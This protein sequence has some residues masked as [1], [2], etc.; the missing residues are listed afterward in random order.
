M[1]TT[2]TIQIVFD[3]SNLAHINS[4]GAYMLNFLELINENGGQTLQIG[5]I[6]TNISDTK[7]KGYEEE[8][9]V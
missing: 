5:I 4:H 1:N 8:I 9:I 7:S 2:G 6:S 3:L